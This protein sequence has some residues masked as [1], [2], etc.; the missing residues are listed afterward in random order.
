MLREIFAWK[1]L[2]D[3]VMNYVNKFPTC[4]KNKVQ[5]SHPSSLLHPLP[6]PT[7]K[8]E[9]ISMDFITGL[10]KVFCKDCIFVVV[11]S[12]TKFAHL[13]SVTTTFFAAQVD[14]LF[15]K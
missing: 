10:P 3:D 8:W 7:Q 2:K 9:S 6:I 14:G 15:F 5:N 12:L 13:F 11:D 4:K 1:W